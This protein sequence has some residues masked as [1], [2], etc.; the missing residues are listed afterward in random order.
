VGEYIQS[1]RSG[2]NNCVETKEERHSSG[3]SKF[4]GGGTFSTQLKG[5]LCYRMW[6]GEKM[7]GNKNVVHFPIIL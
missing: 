2:S 6:R 5:K 1:K 7:K 3:G 4:K